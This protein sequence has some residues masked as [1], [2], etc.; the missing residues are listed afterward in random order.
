MKSSADDRRTPRS[1]KTGIRVSA[2][3]YEAAANGTIKFRGL[4]PREETGQQRTRDS[5]R[6]FIHAVS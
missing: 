3:T 4:T 5:A 6:I 1:T 2:L